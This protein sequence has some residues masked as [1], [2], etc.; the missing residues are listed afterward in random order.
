M[1]LKKYLRIYLVLSSF[2]SLAFAD[3]SLYV[4]GFQEILGNTTKQD[5][6]LDYSVEHNINTLLLYELHL[7]LVGDLSNP[8]TTQSLANFIAKAKTLYGIQKITAV[9]ENVA[10]FNSV[11]LYNQAHSAVSERID[12]Y[13][14]EFEF[15][16]DSLIVPGGYYCTTYLQPNGYTCDRTGAFQFYLGQLT[17][18]NAL[19]DATSFG[20]VVETYVGWPSQAEA[21]AIV[22]IVDRV[23]LH[24]YRPS[25]ETAFAYTEERLQF[26]AAL[27]QSVNVYVIFS[28]ESEFMQT[29]LESNSMLAAEQIY[30]DDYNSAVGTWKNYINLCGFTYF[31]YSH[32]RNTPLITQTLSCSATTLETLVDCIESFM[33][34]ANSNGYIK[35]SAAELSDWQIL[36][37]DMLNKSCKSIRL[38]ANLEGIYRLFDFTDSGTGATY[39]VAMEVADVDNNSVVDRGLATLIVNPN[40]DIRLV[41]AAP[42]SLYDLNT[43]KQA[44][45]VFKQTNAHLFLLNGSHRNANTTVSTCQAEY[46]ESDMAHNADNFFQASTQTLQQYYQAKSQS[47]T[48]LQFHGMGSS[49]CVGTDVYMTFGK[50]S[51]PLANESLARLKFHLRCEQPT[52]S[53]VLP[54]ELQTCDLSGGTNVQG[55]FLNGVAA[56]NVCNTAAANYSTRFIHMEQKLAKR[57][58]EFFD[59]WSRAVRNTFTQVIVKAKVWLQGPFQLNAGAGSMSDY[60]SSSNLLP[61]QTPY[62]EMGWDAAPVTVQE[63][64]TGQDGAGVV[65]WVFL[66][67]RS[68][69]N[70]ATMARKSAFID[71]NGRLLD[72]TANGFNG[73]AMNATPGS[74]YLVIKH[75][76]HAA[77]MSAAAIDFSAADLA[78][79]DFTI[80][81]ATFYNSGAAIQLEPGIWGVAAGDINTD[82]NFTTED[83]TVFFNQQRSA[84][85]AFQSADLNFDGDVTSADY[86]IW[87]GN[88]YA[89]ARSQVPN[90]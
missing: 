68:P 57:Q 22:P 16:N 58:D 19:A 59:D 32:G 3:R 60:L 61:K 69:A 62:Y 55:R 79:Y 67:L 56:E 89:G 74:Y 81:A 6:L 80:G 18:I 10:F 45:S 29:W 49:S 86:T 2:T 36:V 48:M 87:F 7:V 38:P 66:E 43:G 9:G 44:V 11:G 39:S 40:S 75:R 85:H 72:L 70:G 50:S 5:S 33:P 26:F 64:P 90:Y 77:V 31:A 34:A 73:I 12:V 23:L 53:V 28:A 13:N 4:N 8:A 42:H 47:F 46:K 83:F 15:W 30:D 14:L 35:P 88:A 37:N 41:I 21:S 1:F 78:E 54:G 24:A 20:I 25:P 17:Q 71:Q 63:Y 76:N 82:G 65:D 84:L 27:Q 51:A 52:W